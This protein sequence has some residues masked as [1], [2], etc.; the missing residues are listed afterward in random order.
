[1]NTTRATGIHL[2][3]NTA[4]MYMRM[5]LLM[6]ISLYTSRVLLNQLGIDDY[7]I[8]NLV[9]SI[10]MMFSSLR[11][12][13][14]STT[15]RF[16]NYEMGVQNEERLQLIYCTST[17][18]NYII[19]FVF[20][21]MVEGIGI[22]FLMFEA[23][24]PQDRIVAAHF[25][26]QFSILSAV[27]NIT[28]T[29]FDALVIAHE[30][31][32]FYAYLSIFEG[33]AKLI[34]CYLLVYAPFDK[35]IYYGLLI[36]AVSI[37]SRVISMFFCKI[38]F[39]ECKFRFVWDKDC[40]KKMSVF[41]GWSFF[42][43]T[44]FVLSQNGIN[45][46]LNIFGGPVVNAARGIANQVNTALRQFVVNISVVVKPYGIK[47]Y[48]SG[49]IDKA[50]H[51]SYL[52]A[53]IYFTVQMIMTIS[54]SFFASEILKM[55]LGRVPEYTAVF[56]DL[57]LVQAMFQSF[58][59]PI[60]MLFSAEGDIKIYQITEGILLAMPVPVAFLFLIN[61]LPFYS[62]YIGVIIF[63]ILNLFSISLIASKKCHLNLKDYYRGVLLP[64]FICMVIYGVLFMVSSMYVA[65]LPKI[66]LFV[67]TLVVELILMLKVG[68]NKQEKALFKEIILSKILKKWKNQN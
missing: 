3:K 45:M 37:A 14:A 17:I 5:L 62:V 47:T 21:V 8:Y 57:V 38:K 25:V 30:R 27:I 43:N 32:D 15:Q 65:L 33:I 4:F 9:G 28:S 1:M 60:D 16:L 54:V 40:I 34:I 29:P 52:S 6:F 53:K 55:W 36:M 42:G 20:F 48:S 46:I 18:I 44:A 56:L 26:L 23:N 22:W 63:E 66:C 61:G 58:L 50:L 35:L 2:A 39:Q 41:A 12:M 10:V 11:A 59:S 67:L 19:A 68:F 64:C 51:L 24:I 49:N 31:M 13:F 7:G